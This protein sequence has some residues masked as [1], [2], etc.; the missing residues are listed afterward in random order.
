MSRNSASTKATGGGGYTFADKVAAAFL[1]QM[2]RRD[3]PVEP[4]FGAISELHFETRDTGQIVDDLRL[5]LKRGTALTRCAISVKSNRQLTRAGFN[6]EFVVD[7]WEEWNRQGFNQE[8]D[9]LGLVVGVID[10]PTLD[11]W[12]ELQKQDFATTPERIIER[13][14]D[15]Q[16]SSAIQRAI[17]ES[18]RKEQNGQ[19]PD[20]LDAGRLA[21]RIRVLPFVEGDEGRY[22]N[23]CAE[24]T[25]PGSIEEGTK[26]WSRLL[27]LA[28]ENRATGGFFDVVKLVRVL[29]PDFEL[30]DY[31][32]Y[33]AD[34]SRIE[35]VS[36]QNVSNVRTVLGAD[37]HL[38]R[39]EELN[40][41][42][43]AI[44]ADDV[45]VIVGES[46]SGKSS[47][48]S[49]LVAGS[50]VFK[51]ILWLTPEQ[52]SKPSQ[53]ELSQA[54]Q[55]RHGLSEMISGSGVKNS[56]LVIDGFEKFEGEARKR[57]QELIA[58][59]KAE[60]FVGWKLIVTCQ[61][62]SWESA[63][64]ALIEAGITAMH[65]LDFSV[66]TTQEIYDAI[67]H[68]PEIRYLLMRSL[69]R[70][71]LR[72]LVM[73]DWVL[74][75]GIAK[76][77]SDSSQVWIGETDLINWI[78]DRWTGNGSMRFARDSLL[79]A[80]GRLEGDKLSGAV[81]IDAI[82]RDQLP[83][84]GTLAREGLIRENLPSIQFPHD[85]MGD[86]ARYRALSFAE[87]SAATEIRALASIPRWGRAIRLFA[88]SLAEKKDGLASWKSML[89]RLSGAEAEA[90]LASDIFLDGLVFAANS[91][92]LLELVWPNLIAD[93]GT[94]LR[95]LLKRLQNA[96]SIPDV[97]LRG[98]V[99]PK[100]AEQSEAWFRIPHPLYWSPALSVLS[101]HEKDVAEDALLLGGEICGLWLRTMPKE[102]PGRREAALL[103]MELAKE[104]QARIA[105]DRHFG[106]KD[107]V[108]YE[109]LLWAATEFPDEVAEIA[110][111]LSGRRDEPEHAIA[112]AIAA[113]EQERKQR[114]EWLKTHPPEK[115]PKR[116]RPP[117]MLS[118]PRGPLRT[119]AADGPAREVPEGLRAAVLD[120][121]A[122]S[123]LIAVRPAA[124]AEV[125]LAV[126]I[127]EPKP[128]DPYGDRS[129][130]FDDFGLS[131]WQHGYPAY[132]W[133]G[134]FL[135]FVQ[136]APDQGLDA[137]I[138]LV[139]Y[140]TQRWLEDVGVRL[141]EEQ[142][143]KYGLE[144]EFAAKTVCWLGDA[145]VFG[146]HRYL[147]KDGDVVEAALMAL[148]KWLYDEVKAGR[149]IAQW[150]QQIYDR[151]ESLA[152]AGVLVAV[153]MKYPGLFTKELQPLLGNLHLYECQ[154]SWAV[155]ESQEAWTIALSGQPQTV[156]QWALEWHRM[157]HRRAF[158]RDNAPVLMM[159]DEGIRNY[160]VGRA[161]EWAKQLTDAAG[162][163]DDLRFFLARFDLKNYTETPQADGTVMITMRWPEEL[164]AKVKEGQDDREL[165]IVSLTLSST[166]RA[167]L[168]GRKEL[169]RAEVP[170]FARQTRRLADWHPS[171][172]DAQQEQYRVNSL[173]GGIAVLIIEHRDWLKQ[174]PDIEKWCMD[175]LR[176]LKPAEG[177]EL[178]SSVSVLDYTAE[179][180]LGEAGVALLLESDE[181]WVLRLVFEGVTGFYYN[182]TFQT[183]VGAF[184]LRERLGGKFA[185][186]ANIVV[187]WSA[188]R[189]A[190][191]RESGY[192]ARLDLLA[193][194]KATLFRRY[195][196][197]ELKGRLL[198]L[199]KA[200]T[201]GKSLV[202]RVDRRTES[203]EERHQRA[204]RKE[205]GREQKNRK[206]DR[207]IP[208]I[209]FRVLQKGFGFLWGMVREPLPSDEPMLRH[210]VRGLFDLEMRTL[211][212]PGPDEENYEIE[213]TAYEFDVW[214]MAR[215]AEF[216][217]KENSA[218]GARRFYG[219][220]LALGPAGRYWVEDFLQ[221][222]V[223][224]GLEMTSD[225]AAFAKIWTEMVD[226]AMALPAWQPG[227]HGCWSRAESLAVDLV[228]L[229]DDSA[230][231]LG[232]AKH[233][234]LVQA[235]APVFERW[236][237]AWLNHAS[238][239]GWF[240]HFLATESGNVLLVMGIKELAKVVG[241]F[242]DRDWHQQ[243]LGGIFTDALAACWRRKQN[244]IEQQPEL[245]KSF[246]QILTEL[247]ARQIPEALHLRNK[248]S[249]ALGNQAQSNPAPTF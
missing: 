196:A 6:Q 237:K 139:N 56:V 123:S 7:A 26:L 231:V 73:L 61:T 45:V 114:E 180:F 192:E 144:F 146:W 130:L 34:W 208:S 200:E 176:E 111:E 43:Q 241:S 48:V 151:A 187:L 5:V 2:L 172:L 211:P 103:A 202:E 122:L 88:Q 118:M 148:E 134:P 20:A 104:L 149:S 221:T 209:D 11:A 132:Y 206:L 120:T 150:V 75:A 76:R 35:S 182:S 116:P 194:Y 121:G 145:N 117:V 40:R 168:S 167:C 65:K 240:S 70:P 77:L 171:G 163:R 4:A 42:S 131:D 18:L 170:E 3:F 244:E 53:A 198:P 84:L 32:E 23:L 19:K 236:S 115:R 205:W 8:T 195:A 124:A 162:D 159:Q 181:E 245:R 125:L 69:L 215:I 175:T 110:L 243:G 235:M 165:K 177:S 141:T 223:R 25:L 229:R 59:V 214:V 102:V 201:L 193:K 249:E 153:G 190:A 80:L 108:V 10:P 91:E 44:T 97:R 14:K 218:D 52:V 160:L 16:Q 57:T 133:K 30:R 86:W 112:R 234:A 90:V 101:R 74:R 67:P 207:D 60:S 137:I 15:S 72:N 224:I 217:V 87:N 220:I 100:Y 82:E 81:H 178:D 50:G 85:L 158:L 27:Q 174:N 47:L 58:A 83:L 188:L 140:A 156:I 226:Y 204:L 55:L 173:A 183:M 68:L 39:T 230:V 219:P 161:A 64:D 49:Q 33:E 203:A 36:R 13:L 135:T 213:G 169:Q 106:D 136:I 184:W 179:S 99:D 28:A 129:R 54:F 242:E 138:R 228:G 232:Q 227:A 212:T 154:T 247:C 199:T 143:A 12:R 22:M 37:I 46:G 119:Q 51:R 166:A 41:V 185:E 233:K 238:A 66:P 79:R 155:N 63:Q 113:Q 9:L 95:R 210:Y 78:W 189:R 142:R 147:P 94:I 62:Q 105:E 17:F 98:L 71:I 96:A 93:G 24:I 222:W 225:P 164:E 152:F 126:C 239:A 107:K 197:G 21:S 216:I 29:R 191:N 92:I 246:L 128:T 157:P 186:L 38:V 109:A 248:V 31:P 127:E 1:T 89:A